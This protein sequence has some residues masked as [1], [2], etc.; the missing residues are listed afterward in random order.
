MPSLAT[1]Q[2]PVTGGKGIFRRRRAAGAERARRIA[3]AWRKFAA[4]PA[5]AGGLHAANDDFFTIR[6]YAALSGLGENGTTTS[7]RGADNG[8]ASH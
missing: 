8:P 3:I 5:Q 2:A 6:P 4:R 7:H 1:A